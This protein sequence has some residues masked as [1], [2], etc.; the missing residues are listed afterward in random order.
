[1]FAGN[2]A[3]ASLKL[4]E[5]G[6][7]HRQ[8]LD[9]FVFNNWYD[10]NFSDAKISGVELIQHGERIATNG[11][12]RLTAT[13]QQWSA[14]PILIQRIED[15][16]NHSITV[17]LSYPDQD[18][19]YA[20]TVKPDSS[21]CSV[22]VVL[23]KPLPESL[24]GVAGFN[25]E[26][27]PSAY[28]GKGYLVDG[29][30]GVFPLHPSSDMRLAGDTAEPLSLCSG[31]TIV[32]A[33][34]DPQRMVRIES[35]KGELLALYDGRNQAQNGWFVV[36]SMIPSE[37]T[38]TVLEWYV[39]A[40]S[41]ER[42]IRK[43]MIAY[44]QVGYHP[45]EQKLAIIELDTNDSP[46]V[47]AILS[48]VTAD[49][50]KTP[51]KALTLEDAGGYLRYHYYRMDFSD[52]TESGLYT[53]TYGQEKTGVFR[54]ATGIYEDV[55]YPTMDVFFPVQM[56]HMRVREAYR[57]WHGASHLDDALQ[58]PVNHEH[59]DLYGQ[60]PTTDTRFQ[61]GEHIPGLDIGGWYDAGDFDIRTQTQYAVVLN[62]VQLVEQYG[63]S[64][65]QTWVN[66]DAR[67]V[68]IHHPDGVSD[69]LQQIRHGTLALIAQ[70]RTCGHAISG[71]VAAHLQQ[72]THLGDG[73]SKTDNRIYDPELEVLESDGVRSGKFDDRWAFTTHTSALNYG[74]ASALAAASRVLGTI[75]PALASEC[76]QT[77][78]NVWTY[79][80]THAPALFRVG[81]TTGGRLAS[82]QLKAAVELWKST[83]DSSYLEAV[84]ALVPIKPMEFAFAA[85]ILL[86][87]YDS[88]PPN[89]KAIVAERAS[90]MEAMFE[91]MISENPFGVPIT[92][93]GWAG[94]GAVVSYGLTQYWLHKTFPDQFDGS[95]AVRSLHYLYGCHPVHSLSFVSAEGVRS[96]R[97]AYGNNR[98]DFS[99][100][101]GGVVPGILILKPDYPEN[102]ENWPFFWGEN[103]YVVDL[104]SS[105]L[106]L[107]QAVKELSQRL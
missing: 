46:R 87:V 105:Y 88:L 53:I 60:G 73:A 97:V 32:L 99:F 107:V 84:V 64:R 35:K 26:F 23:D 27:L 44:S 10:G 38:G 37:M 25:M 2:H 85:T 52:I 28:W 102:M 51:V 79:E 45:S 83:R 98:A 47:E 40:H 48:K 62:L 33:P 20:I 59:F 58:A 86:P 31:N 70:H 77:A 91:P 104:A 49:G 41:V 56:D 5:N 61:P 92:R 13:P 93:G 36:R 16:D 82:E 15:R 24:R 43:P 78:Q 1:L 22:S 21:G 57:I 4:S 100:I 30:P 94:N 50:R 80:Q 74:S 69:I 14:T 6:Y 42:W 11:D 101:P 68:E 95:G 65:D 7:L 72:Y 71:I 103:E 29:S 8:G 17:D 18:F 19:S 12:I 3:E 106:L 66:W 67:E 75:D 63:V 34:E 54:I 55:W 9:V 89:V 76:L 81:N 96:K 39:E 90:A